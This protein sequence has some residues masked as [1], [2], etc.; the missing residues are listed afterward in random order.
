MVF[1]PLNKPTGIHRVY[2]AFINSCRA[3]LWLYRNEAAFRQ[4]CVLLLVA[5]P[6]SFW[7]GESPLQIALLILSILFI[8]MMEVI[9]TAIEVIVDRI[10]L[11][12]HIKATI[13][14]SIS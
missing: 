8:L 12:I 3:F 14:L 9:N 4:E 13:E 6:F 10:S 5:I 1:D 11:E 2:L 7:L